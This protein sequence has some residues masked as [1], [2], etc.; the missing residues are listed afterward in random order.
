VGLYLRLLCFTYIDNCGRNYMLCQVKVVIGASE[1]CENGVTAIECEHVAR[2]NDLGQTD[3][4][5]GGLVGMMQPMA[6]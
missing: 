3:D 5:L 6:V 4:A 2:R 1:K